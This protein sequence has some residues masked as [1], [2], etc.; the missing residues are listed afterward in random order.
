MRYQKTIPA[1]KWKYLE[2]WFPDH[3]K[4]M[5]FLLLIHKECKLNTLLNTLSKSDDFF[6]F[7]TK[8]FTNEESITFIY[9]LVQTPY[10]TVD[11]K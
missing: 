2:I 6:S 3:R 5:N 10:Y 1:L 8:N 9:I 4:S 11:W 7:C